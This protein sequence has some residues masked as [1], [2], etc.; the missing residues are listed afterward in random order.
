MTDH[1]RYLRIVRWADHRYR[2]GNGELVLSIGNWPSLYSQIEKMAWHRYC[3]GLQ[4]DR[5][6]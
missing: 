5:G 4:C 6:L 2:G 1:N 3:L